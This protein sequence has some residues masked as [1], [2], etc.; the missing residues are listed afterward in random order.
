MLSFTGDFRGML[1]LFLESGLI[2]RGRKTT[3]PDKQFF[4]NR[5]IRLYSMTITQSIRKY[6]E[7]PSRCCFFWIKF[8]RTQD[9]GL[10]CRQAKSLAIIAHDIVPRDC[11]HRVISQN[12]DRIFSGGSQLQGQH[13]KSRSRAIGLCSSSSSSPFARET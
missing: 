7:T 1:N 2:L 5:W 10:Q 11:I 8:S 9:Q 4:S 12:G 13:P 3:N 6:L